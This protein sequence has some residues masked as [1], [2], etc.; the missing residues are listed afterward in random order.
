[1]KFIFKNFYFWFRLVSPQIN[2][3]NNAARE[4]FQL[5]NF[6]VEIK[7]RFC[8]YMS[9][10]TKKITV[11]SNIIGCLNNVNFDQISPPCFTNSVVAHK[12]FYAH[13]DSRLNRERKK[14]CKGMSQGRVW[15]ASKYAALLL[16]CKKIL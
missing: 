15:Q 1:M 5:C 14:V 12:K 4:V 8:K 2:A 6:K 10:G 7:K 9:F 16:W 11:S 13:M 3:C